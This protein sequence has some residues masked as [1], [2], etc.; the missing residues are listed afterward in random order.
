MVVTVDRGSPE[1]AYQQLS[2]ILRTRIAAGEWSH[3]PL[4][5]IRQ[6]QQEYDVGRDTVIRALEV[7]EEEGLVFTVARRG[8]Y[9][10][11]KQ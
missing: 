3:G 1:P 10:S 9:V 8:T 6:L 2:G 7:L 4:P 5:S 11:P